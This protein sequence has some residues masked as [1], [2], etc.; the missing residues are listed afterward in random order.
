MSVDTGI[1]TRTIVSGIAKHFKPEE[2]VGKQVSVLANLA[3]R[4]IMGVESH[5]MILLAENHDGSLVF[6]SPES[7]VNNGSG[8]S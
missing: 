7:E 2:V 8:V 3:P 1:D 4:K 5:G 6:V